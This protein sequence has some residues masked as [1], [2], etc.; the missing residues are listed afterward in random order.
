MAECDYN[1]S[2]SKSFVLD[3]LD[4]EILIIINRITTLEKKIEI[5]EK[6]YSDTNYPAHML[7]KNEIKALRGVLGNES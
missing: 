2:F 1:H 4:A 5:L 7:A 3:H 6:K